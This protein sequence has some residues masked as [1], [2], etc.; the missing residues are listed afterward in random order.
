MTST[1][2]L[3]LLVYRSLK[4]LI[5]IL[6]Y[7]PNVAFEAEASR[8]YVSQYVDFDEVKIHYVTTNQFNNS[9]KQDQ[10]LMLFPHGFPHFWYS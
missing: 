10:P 2:F 4:W 3:R 7:L 1:N 6:I 8:H 9:D 5:Y